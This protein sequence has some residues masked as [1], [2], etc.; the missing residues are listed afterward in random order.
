MEKT[1]WIKIWT[2]IFFQYTPPRTIFILAANSAPQLQLLQILFK[3]N[4]EQLTI[5]TYNRE[6]VFS[7]GF[8]WQRGVTQNN[9]IIIWSAWSYKSGYIQNWKKG[10]I[11]PRIRPS[12]FI[13]ICQTGQFF[14]LLQQIKPV[15]AFSLTNF[16][17]QEHQAINKCKDTSFLNWVITKVFSQQFSG[18]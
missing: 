6:K 2:Y 17:G 16:L 14:I 11:L 12:H 1:R 4:E 18:L 7:I 13:N 3:T 10:R 9:D 8:S 15:E 5:V